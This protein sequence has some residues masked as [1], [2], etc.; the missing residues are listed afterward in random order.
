[1]SDSELLYEQDGHVVVLTLNR[2]ERMNA[3]NRHLLKVALPQAFRRAAADP[4]VRVV[5]LTGAG[6]KVFC[7]GADLK[8]TAES[9]RIGN[10]TEGPYYRGSPTDF[11]HEGFDKPV[12]GIVGIRPGAV[13]RAG[14]V[15]LRA[16]AGRHRDKV[17]DSGSASGVRQQVH[18][19]GIGRTV[20]TFQVVGRCPALA[21]Q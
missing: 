9:G 4:E 20:R 16:D 11:L 1:M 3:L 19:A 17:A 6:E 15:G 2:P 5:V 10:S 21:A 8:D 18:G 14:R 7:A 12:I 13:G